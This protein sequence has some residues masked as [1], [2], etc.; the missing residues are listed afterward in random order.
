MYGG[1]INVYGGYI[2]VY[3]EYINVYGGYIQNPILYTYRVIASLLFI[4]CL[5]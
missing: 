3:G 1:Y 4:K 5:N 2:N